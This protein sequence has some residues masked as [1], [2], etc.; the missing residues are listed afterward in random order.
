M[1]VVKTM[2]MQEEFHKETAK[3]CLNL[4]VGAFLKFQ[5]ANTDMVVC[6]LRSVSR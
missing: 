6:R 5:G 4:E 3:Y 1:V 2:G